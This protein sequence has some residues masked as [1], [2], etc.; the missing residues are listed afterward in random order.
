MKLLTN[1]KQHVKN[2]K[3]TVKILPLFIVLSIF[4]ITSL[5]TDSL[6]VLHLGVGGDAPPKQPVSA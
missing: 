5:F 4:S 1:K 3:A 2:A 6:S